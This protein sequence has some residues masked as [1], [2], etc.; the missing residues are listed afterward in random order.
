[1]KVGCFSSGCYSALKLAGMRTFMK[2]FRFWLPPA[3]FAA[4]IFWLSSL[5][6]AQPAPFFHWL[7]NFDKVI[8]GTI[9]AVLGWLTLRALVVGESM[10]F[11]AGAVAAFLICSAYGASDEWHQSVVPG[12]ESDPYDW[13]ADSAGALIAIVSLYRPYTSRAISRVDG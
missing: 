6:G 8:H 10:R 13:L 11:P 3:A 4:L 2:F 7:K 9:Y 12:R 5:M 1:M